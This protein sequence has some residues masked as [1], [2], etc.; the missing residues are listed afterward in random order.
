MTNITFRPADLTDAE[1]LG[2]I[3]YRAF[4]K[5]A[6]AHN[7]PPD[8]PDPESGV[9]LARMMIN[10]SDVFSVVAENGSVLGSNFLWEADEVDGVGPITID[11][12]AQNSSIGRELMLRVIKRSEQN[13]KAGIRLVQAAYHNRS[14][15]L[16]TK[17]GFD[18]VEP[19]S[20]INGRP[21]SVEMPG[22]SIRPLTEG[23]VDAANRLCIAAH[24]IS[25]K[26]EIAG[27]AGAGTGMVVENEGRLSGYTTQLGFFGHSVAETNDDLKALIG[28]AREIA[29]PGFLLPTRNGEVLRWCLEN[30]LRIVMPLS[31][32]KKGF[33]QTPRKHFMPSI[34]Y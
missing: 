27:A 32:M 26:N 7:F 25:R 11:P 10:R 34:L 12:A 1:Q 19:L 17:L 14:L 31:L 13:R 30:G 33:Y 20:A 18:V 28:S 3:A 2:T 29:G 4:Y 23:D 5:V 9:G 15:A 21:I 16:Y 24:G 6:T 22:R 8:F